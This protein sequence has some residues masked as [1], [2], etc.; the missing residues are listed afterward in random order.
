MVGSSISVGQSL[1]FIHKQTGQLVYK[2]CSFRIIKFIFHV[3]MYTTKQSNMLRNCSNTTSNFRMSK[4]QKKGGGKH[5][6]LFPKLD[7]YCISCFRWHAAFEGNH[8]NHGIY[9]DAHCPVYWGKHTPL[10][11]CNVASLSTPYPWA[12][13]EA[14]LRFWPRLVLQDHL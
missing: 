14:F 5:S 6:F 9:V 12:F 10:A 8:Y 2:K 11:Q 7:D 3:R 1:A 4:L 13:L